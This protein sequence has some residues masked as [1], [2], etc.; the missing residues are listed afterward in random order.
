LAG[1]WDPGEAGLNVLHL[2]DPGSPDGGPC[3]LRTLA[4]V[5]GR[6]DSIR[7]HVLVLGTGGAVAWAKR[8]GVD[9]IGSVSLRAGPRGLNRIIRTCERA[10]RDFDVIHSWSARAAATAV[11]AST[12][13]AHVAT[14]AMPP[15]NE[16]IVSLLTESGMKIL[17]P[18]DCHRPRYQSLGFSSHIIS[19]FP[20]AIDSS[21]IDHPARDEVRKQWGI[22][23]AVNGLHPFVVGMIADDV[24]TVD[25]SETNTLAARLAISGRAVRMVV[26]SRAHRRSEAE[27]VSHHMAFESEPLIVDDRIAEPW[28]IAAGLDAAVLH[29]PDPDLTSMMPVLWVMAAGIPVLAPQGRATLEVIEDDRCGFIINPHNIN[30]A[31]DRLGRLHDD[32]DLSR[33]LG[34]TGVDIVHQRFDPED[35]CARLLEIYTRRGA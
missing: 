27:A 10:R 18:M 33:Q 30:A 35:V 23:P 29:C 4:A 13:H 21:A 6:L 17:T 16:R 32:R 3:T 5:L 19:T 25:A 34:R 2:V 31:C 12:G 22:T 15:T 11:S 7:H 1:N 14:I 28:T 8:C 26:H 20:P 9:S 24:A